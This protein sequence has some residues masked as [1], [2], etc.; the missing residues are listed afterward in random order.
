MS[1]QFGVSGLFAC[2]EAPRDMPREECEDD[3]GTRVDACPSGGLIC[4]NSEQDTNN[5][6]YGQ[7]YGQAVSSLTCESF[8]ME[9]L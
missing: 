6:Y 1:D 2:A 4:Y 8:G 9:E 5:H 3:G 7:I